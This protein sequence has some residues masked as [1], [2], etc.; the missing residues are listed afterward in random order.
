MTLIPV[1]APVVS[2]AFDL[3]NASFDEN[4]N[5]RSDSGISSANAFFWRPTSNDLCIAEASSTGA[6]KVYHHPAILGDMAPG[7]AV[8]ETTLKTSPS[9]NETRFGFRCGQ[10][11]DAGE[12]L[13]LSIGAQISKYALATAYTGDAIRSADEQLAVTSSDTI[14]GFFTDDTGDSIYFTQSGSTDLYVRAMSTS[15]D[16]TTMGASSVAFS[17]PETTV[18]CA[19]VGKN[20]TRLL[21]V[22]GSGDV[23]EYAGGQYDFTNFTERASFATGNTN[24][25]YAA[26]TP[27]GKHMHTLNSAT[28]V[29]QYNTVTP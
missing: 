12:T 29:R 7:N 11:E 4:Y 1:F 21:V 14:T 26:Y 10:W 17:I 8:Q 2:K 23:V 24:I 20:G 19:S 3:S 16:I 25:D 13:F 18:R 22:N 15:F 28:D 27:I 6:R 5:P 9:T